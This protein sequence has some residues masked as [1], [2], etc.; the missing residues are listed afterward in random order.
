MDE[1]KEQKQDTE[2]AL[3]NTEKSAGKQAERAERA[4]NIC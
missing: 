1:D 3:G 4:F 2:V